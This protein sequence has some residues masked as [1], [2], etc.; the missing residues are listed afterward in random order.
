MEAQQWWL[1][2]S[3]LEEEDE[4]RT[5]QPLTRAPWA[6]LYSGAQGYNNHLRVDDSN[7]SPSRTS[8]QWL[9]PL[10]FSLISLD[11]TSHPCTLYFLDCTLSSWSSPIHEKVLSLIVGM[12]LFGWLLHP[13][14]SRWTYSGPVCRTTDP[15]S[16]NPA[17]PYSCMI[18]QLG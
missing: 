10:T 7:Y 16:G 9:P 6:T 3:L 11:G 1:L 2:S 18:Y 15:W 14:H 13:G 4:L 12:W 8:W 17:N 5:N